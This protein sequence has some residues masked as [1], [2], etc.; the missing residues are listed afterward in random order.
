MPTTCPV[1]KEKGWGIPA[2]YTVQKLYEAL[3][4]EIRKPGAWER[5][6]LVLV[7]FLS[8]T[9]ARVSEALKATVDDLMFDM[10]LIRIK[11]VKKRV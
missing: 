10:G 1:V 5:D 2:L 4:V 3:R 9:G 11:G 7:A 8:Y 6:S